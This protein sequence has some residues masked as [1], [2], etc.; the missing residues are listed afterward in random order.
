MRIVAGNAPAAPLDSAF[1]RDTQPFIYGSAFYRP[2]NPP[3]S[4]R[5]EMLKTIAQDYKFNIIRIYPAWAY[6]NPAPDRFDFGELEEVVKYC[7]DFGLRILMGVVI[8]EMPYWLEGLHPE[9]RFVDARGNFQRLSDSGNN[10]SGGWPGLCLDWDPIQKAAARFIQQDGSTTT[11]PIAWANGG[12]VIAAGTT[13]VRALET[14]ALDGGR[15]GAVGG[16][17]VARGDPG[18]RG[19]GGGRAA[20][21]AA[22]AAVLAPADAG[23]VRRAGAARLVL[24]G[25]HHVG[26]PVAR[27]RGRA[28]DAAVIFVCVVSSAARSSRGWQ[29]SWTAIAVASSTAGRGGFGLAPA[30]QYR[31][32]VE[33]AVGQMVGG[34]QLA[35]AGDRGREPGPVVAARRARARSRSARSMGATRPGWRASS[36]ASSSSVVAGSS[37]SQAVR[38][39]TGQ[40]QRV[41]S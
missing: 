35:Q 41:T 13:V 2:P 26:V 7:D 9:T 14:A 38:A 21:R 32:V 18:D 3:P 19:P 6:Y 24:R 5:K 12:R 20:H 23:R 11:W 25:G 16:L 39:A 22:R 37:S 1:P 30:G 4:M 8:E 36:M 10:V 17:D 33:Q 31:G 40:A 28:P 27:V 34:A 29:R 15:G